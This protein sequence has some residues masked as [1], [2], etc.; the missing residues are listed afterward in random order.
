MYYCTSDFKFFII[1]QLNVEVRGTTCDYLDS[2]RESML[3][4]L[5]TQMMSQLES[6]AGESSIYWKF[7]IKKALLC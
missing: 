6:L 2:N 3:V 4:V 1:L 5:Q 7:K